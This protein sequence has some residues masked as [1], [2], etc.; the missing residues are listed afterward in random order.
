MLHPDQGEL[1]RL[2]KAIRREGLTIWCYTGF[3]IEQVLADGRWNELL[4][5]LEVL[6]DGPF[7]EKR[8]T[9]SLPFRGSDNQR[10]IRIS[11]ILQIEGMGGH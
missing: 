8:R 7:V 10:L 1:L 6:V 4:P 3:T 9:L 5:E 11:D 2:A